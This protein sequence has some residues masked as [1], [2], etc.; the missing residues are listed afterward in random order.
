MQVHRCT[1][2]GDAPD[3]EGPTTEN[4]GKELPLADRK[5]KS[6]AAVDAAPFIIGQVVLLIRRLVRGAPGQHGSHIG[7][8][9]PEARRVVRARRERRLGEFL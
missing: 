7:I 1:E 8:G 3:G 5:D 2:G 9:A 6:A 4:I